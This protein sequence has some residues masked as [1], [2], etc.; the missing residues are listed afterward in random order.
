M[1]IYTVVI[2]ILLTY[3]LMMSCDEGGDNVIGSRNHDI[4][5]ATSTASEILAN[6]ISTAQ[7]IANVRNKDGSIAPNM[8]VHF[9]TTAG[10][11]EEYAISDFMGDAEVTLTSTASDSDLIAEITATVVDTTFSP[12]NR[13][14]ACPYTITLFV[15]D[16]E[17]K[18]KKMRSLHKAGQQ[19]DNRSTMQVK[20]LGVTLQAEMEETVLPADGISQAKVD[21]RLQE[22]TSYKA[23]KN[24]KIHAIPKYGSIA[25][26]KV[27]DESGRLELFLVADDQAGEDTL[28]I[29]YGNKM[30]KE[31][32]ISY[33]NPKLT[34]TPRA[35]QVPADGASKIQ[36][37]ANLLSHRNT[38]IEGAVIKFST[39]NGV[40]PESGITDKNGNATVDLTSTTEP[41]SMVVVISR[42]HSLI[43]TAYVSFVTSSQIIPNSILLNADPNFIWVKETG[44]IDQTIISA[45]VLGVNNQPLGNDIGVKFYIVNSPGGGEYIVPS[46]GTAMESTVIP[47]V[48]GIAKATI[49]S[50]TRSGTVQIKAE[51]VDFPEIV[52]QTTNIV[53]RSGPPYMWI[54]PA[55]AN[56]VIPHVTL[57]IEPGKQNV[58]FGNPIQDI[59]MTIY[60]GDKYN[61]PIENGTAVY[62]TTTGGMITSD[63]ITCEKGQTSAILKNVYPF[64]YLVS[65][66]P[67][68]LTSL[69][70]PNPNNDS[71]MLDI[72]HPDFEKGEV[73]NSLGTTTEND[74]MAVILAYT[75]GQDQNGNN[76]K[77]WTT[78]QV[79]YSSSVARFTAVTNK[80]ELAVGESAIIDIRVYDIH[81]NPVAAG[82]RLSATTTAGELSNDNLIS[83]ATRWG[84]GTTYFQTQLLNNLN[85]DEDE[86]T[87]ATVKV[88]LDSPN[89]TG[90]IV[91]KIRLKI[92]P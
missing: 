56:N 78:G 31:F 48:D 55:D 18:N 40:I 7:I 53:I 85:P 10:T 60:F 45:T 37:N 80:T 49:R 58:A 73:I 47:T 1:K 79:I 51:L 16:F 71:L 75:W 26:G 63:A 42:F 82:S 20:F 67:N 28:W 21:I 30:T 64:P 59:Q 12:L 90:I 27:T 34:L 8:K 15:P 5:S 83:G 86:A 25:S 22:T 3:L 70:I 46:S 68:Q 9:E 61:N 17:A 24:A 91:L 11:I 89:G 39:S 41:D 76:I 29:V 57:A 33:I 32:S 4:Y 35:L 87:D 23:I 2:S 92:T 54:D 36:I 52:S 38:P 14:S 84:F 72:D 66:D 69:T 62:F 43:D 88:E 13:N 81:G 50:G 19:Q 74:G 6:G 44:N 65:N 77:V